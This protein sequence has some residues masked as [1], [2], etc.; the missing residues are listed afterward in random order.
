M[1]ADDRDN[2]PPDWL[3][4]SDDDAQDAGGLEWLDDEPDDNIASA[5]DWMT[6]PE[7][8][9]QDEADAPAARS[10]ALAFADLDSGASD[11]SWEL[12]EDDLS[13][14]DQLELA[15]D[16]DDAV[17]DWL[18]GVGTG[19]AAEP[20]AE[21]PDWLS[22]IGAAGLDAGDA[23][24][25]AEADDDQVF[26]WGTSTP[27]AAG[28]GEDE[29]FFL[30]EASDAD[31]EAEDEPAFSWLASATA[32]DDEADELPVGEALYSFSDAA[33]MTDD[34]L[35]DGD[36]DALFALDDEIESNVPD[37]LAGV[38]VDGGGAP[39]A[40]MA[41][42][43]DADDDGFE[44]DLVLAD[45][46][47][48]QEEPAWLQNVGSGDQAEPLRALADFGADD[49]DEVGEA[50]DADFALMFEAEETNGDDDDDPLGWMS[51]LD[52]TP[53]EASALVFDGLPD[54]PDADVISA[55]D[56]DAGSFSWLP[57]TGQLDLEENRARDQEL[58]A[59][60]PDW[61][62]G[63]TVDGP[64]GVAFDA[65][66]TDDD[67]LA[68]FALD[69][70]DDEADAADDAAEV[71]PAWLS[72]MGD[73]ADE[74]VVADADEISLDFDTFDAL[75]PDDALDAPVAGSS[76]P[77]TEFM[78]SE[79]GG[80]DDE[81]WFTAF[82]QDLDADESQYDFEQYA[83]VLGVEL[84]ETVEALSEDN[85]PAWLNEMV[86][87][88]DLDY[89]DQ[90]ADEPIEALYPEGMTGASSRDFAWLSAIVDQE[91]A[92]PMT[93]PT[94]G[95]PA[96]A[97]SATGTGPAGRVARFVMSRPPAW[98]RRL[99]ARAEQGGAAAKDDDLPPWLN[100]DDE[101]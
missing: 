19:A 23:G 45:A 17:P 34:D 80:D 63:A 15:V 86:P 28:S 21:V 31:A 57:T 50:S 62:T 99:G 42:A 41:D 25:D 9:A 35:L 96:P 1:M 88:L 75:E 100:L 6:D 46:D 7:T 49:D 74:A 95:V 51:S 33:A 13:S 8:D 4:S 89:A 77:V 69:F 43:R 64:E 18:S 27:P 85:A 66:D 61:L 58:V 52:E 48:D 14:D 73:E 84:P 93:L 16:E 20:S 53:D 37:W 47:D 12:D 72:G 90:D 91:L 38:T 68:A 10:G 36:D 92:P 83:D 60:V 98:L 81:G 32:D 71:V 5:L 44:L 55:D 67:G 101:D 26:G 70:E 76:V 22:G 78:V 11:F 54:A 79:T 30:D 82:D 97:A 94:P 87:G 39:D 29:L 3:A 56:D 24:D 59:N 40:M 2:R 65:L